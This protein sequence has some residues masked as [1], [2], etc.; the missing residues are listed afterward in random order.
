MTKD[1][2]TRQIKA[3]DELSRIFLRSATLR[4]T[5]GGRCEKM[6]DIMMSYKC[7][8]VWM[9]ANYY[10]FGDADSFIS[11]IKERYVLTSMGMYDSTSRE[12]IL[13]NLYANWQDSLRTINI[14]RMIPEDNKALSLIDEEI[15]G[16]S[17]SI[18]SFAKI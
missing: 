15:D 17:N 12:G 1:Q 9:Y 2:L 13:S 11:D 7:V 5:G 14:M 3:F 8:F 4:S 6:A 18:L 10:R 16:I